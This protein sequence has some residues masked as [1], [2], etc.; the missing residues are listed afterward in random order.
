MHCNLQTKAIFHALQYVVHALNPSLTH[1][2]HSGF[3]FISSP[4]F[5]SML[6]FIEL[7]IVSSN[8]TVIKSH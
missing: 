2:M 3:T 1:L 5:A 7:K 8:A 6:I 4:L